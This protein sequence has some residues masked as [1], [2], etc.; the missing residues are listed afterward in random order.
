MQPHRVSQHERSEKHK[1]N[2]LYRT[3]TTFRPLYHPAPRTKR[4]R[5]H[6]GID[7]QLR[8]SYDPPMPVDV[9]YCDDESGPVPLGDL[10]ESDGPPNTLDLYQEYLEDTIDDD[11]AGAGNQPL[12][13]MAVQEEIGL[14]DDSGDGLSDTV[15]ESSTSAPGGPSDSELME[16]LPNVVADDLSMPAD[17]LPMPADGLPTPAQC[18]LLNS[19][20]ER[21]V[22][23]A[24]SVTQILHDL[25]SINAYSSTKHITFRYFDFPNG[26]QVHTGCEWMRCPPIRRGIHG[27][28]KR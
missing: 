15:S 14:D 10:W 13:G 1:R 8:D 21:Q 18:P 11:G 5:Q 17:D 9:D 2:V 19:A 20:T 24:S 3:S 23:P 27:H 26:A 6:R 12:N 4:H 16:D 22:D 7:S 28:Q 25:E